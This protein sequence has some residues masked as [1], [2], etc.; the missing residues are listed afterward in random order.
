VLAG[1][2]LPQHDVAAYR[3]MIG[4]GIARLVRLA[5]PVEQ[6]YDPI[7]ERCVAL[8][9]AEYGAHCLV[10]TRAY[11]GI[12]EMLAE[13]HN[14]GV[15]LAVLSNKNEELVRRIVAT[16]LGSGVFQVIMGA[17]PD[18]PMKPDPVAALIA[19]ERLGAASGRIAVV[20]DSGSDMQTAAGAGMHA[21]GVSWGFRS[22]DELLVAGAETVLDHPAELA[23]WRA[24]P[25]R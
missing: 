25:A 10:K 19:A 23:A 15:R 4:G 22:R 9:M 5:L 12:P 18:V 17:R 21:V 2:Q 14:D 16:L 3:D 8:M 13:L 6:R 11:D 24:Q 20:G 1:E 7:I